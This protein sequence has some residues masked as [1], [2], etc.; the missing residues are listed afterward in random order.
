M[1]NQ[2]RQALIERLEKI[3]S[4]QEIYGAGSNVV[5]P[6]GEAAEIAKIALAALTAD[7]KA[8]AQKI[9]WMCE[10]TGASYFNAAEW[11]LDELLDSQDNSKEVTKPED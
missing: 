8:I 3:M 9:H 7:R 6:A 5:I 2:E 1:N 11:A 10:R 4:W